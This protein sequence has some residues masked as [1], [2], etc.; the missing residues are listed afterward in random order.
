MNNRQEMFHTMNIMVADV[1][2]TYGFKL[3]TFTHILRKDGKEA[4]E[5]WFEGSS[6][7][8]A[9]NAEKVAYYLTKGAEELRKQDPDHPILWMRAALMNRNELIGIIKNTTRMV[10]ITNGTR[11][12]LIAE[13]SSEET[14]R[15][16]AAML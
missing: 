5:F 10:E 1:L 13:S 16:V 11:S 2:I 15:K 8:C 12:A 6:P 3:I 9:I 14:R 4:K 7:E